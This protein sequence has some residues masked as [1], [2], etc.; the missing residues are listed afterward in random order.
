MKPEYIYEFTG[1]FSLNVRKLKILK[2]MPKSYQVQNK[3]YP[4][5]INKSSIDKVD[6]DGS[7]YSFDFLKIIDAAQKAIKSERN[8]LEERINN[9]HENIRLCG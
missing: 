8:R 1:T 7:F 9:C 3:F 4:F 2:E 6:W 5:R